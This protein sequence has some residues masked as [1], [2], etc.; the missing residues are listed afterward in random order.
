[1]CL[2][3]NIRRRC[4][5]APISASAQAARVQGKA[6]GQG[7][8]HHP[9]FHVNEEQNSST[10]A[11]LPCRTLKRSLSTGHRQ[12]CWHWRLSSELP[13]PLTVVCPVLQAARR[14]LTQVARGALQA[15]NVE[16]LLLAAMLH[17]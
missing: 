16:Q 1:M 7:C 12:H 15:V 9:A 5:K 10:V 8:K 14:Y 11:A 13:R 6:T 2:L 17:S 4:C 3:S